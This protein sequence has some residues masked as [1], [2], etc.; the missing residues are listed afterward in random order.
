MAELV[1][2][3]CSGP[4]QR[5][6]ILEHMAHFEHIKAPQPTR[7]FVAAGYRLTPSAKRRVQQQSL[8]RACTAGSVELRALEEPFTTFRGRD[9]DKLA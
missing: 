4:S 6:A 1:I 8:V 2:Y 9:P 3:G 5:Q 7:E